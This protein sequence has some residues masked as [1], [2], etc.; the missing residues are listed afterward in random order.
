MQICARHRIVTVTIA[1]SRA[2]G[3]PVRHE[4]APT[5][6]ET[7]SAAARG[8]VLQSRQIENTLAVPRFRKSDRPGKVAAAEEIAG[9]VKPAIVEDRTRIGILPRLVEVGRQ[10]EMKKIRIVIRARQSSV[11]ADIQ[12]V[13]GVDL[14][15]INAVVTG[16]HDAV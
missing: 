9:E 12:P 5:D 1:E 14:I 4:S 8:V 16:R 11:A 15:S 2:Q 10:T 7:L 13:T 3:W 6:V